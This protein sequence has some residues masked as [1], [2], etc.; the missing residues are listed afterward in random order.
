M[1]MSLIEATEPKIMEFDREVCTM[2]G[3]QVTLRVAF[4]GIPKP[5]LSWTFNG[6]K[7]EGD[8][9]IEVGT[10]GSLLFV[11]VEKKHSGR[12]YNNNIYCRWDNVYIYLHLSDIILY[13]DYYSGSAV[14]YYNI[15][16]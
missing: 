15:P 13:S 1:I 8:Y 2:E 12:Y 16:V 4:S 10:D 6:S 14:Y 7:V 5:H 11:C 3:K 9:A